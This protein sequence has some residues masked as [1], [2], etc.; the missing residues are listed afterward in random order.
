MNKFSVNILPSVVLS[1]S[2]LPSRSSSCRLGKMSKDSKSGAEL[3]RA[4]SAAK[5][6]HQSTCEYESCW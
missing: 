1:M 3:F 5:R 6:G 4:T 2:W